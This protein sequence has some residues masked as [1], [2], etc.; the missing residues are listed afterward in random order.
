MHDQ[1]YSWGRSENGL[2]LGLRSPAT[3][4]RL[5]ET[6]DLYGAAR[7]LSDRTLRIPGDWSL[8]I[9]SPEEVLHDSQGLRSTTPF[10]LR[11]GETCEVITWRLSEQINQKPGT[12]V[13]TFVHGEARSGEIAIE[14]VVG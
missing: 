7:N 13:C 11:S 14:V 4:I 9:A 12:Y 5:G 10:E 1:D 2:Q 8:T 3:T 6:A